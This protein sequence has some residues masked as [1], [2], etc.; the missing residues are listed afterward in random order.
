MVCNLLTLVVFV[1]DIGPLLNQNTCCELVVGLCGEKEWCAA[2]FIVGIN[3]STIV[4]QKF[5]NISWTT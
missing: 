5:K 2:L 4:D 1:S 3:V